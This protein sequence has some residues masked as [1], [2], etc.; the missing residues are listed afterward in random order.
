MDE[1]EKDTIF[2][3]KK[4]LKKLLP[5]IRKKNGTLIYYDFDNGVDIYECIFKALIR[6]DKRLD[7]LEARLD[8]IDKAFEDSLAR[9]PA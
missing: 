6:F 8:A 3:L 1:L 2:E 5:N 4:D 9:F 7:K